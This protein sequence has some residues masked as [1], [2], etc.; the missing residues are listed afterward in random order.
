M[1]SQLTLNQFDALTLA[2]KLA[3]FGN[4][5]FT[6]K[7]CMILKSM[8]AFNESSLDSEDIANDLDLSKRSV[9]STI[10]SLNRKIQGLIDVD[11]G[12]SNEAY[13][14][15]DN[16]ALS[17]VIC[18][19]ELIEMGAIDFIEEAPAQEI[20]ETPAQEIEET[21]AQETPFNLS[22]TEKCYLKVGKVF[23]QQV[24][25]LSLDYEEKKRQ[26][27]F[28]RNLADS[29]CS[30]NYEKADEILSEFY[31]WTQET[32]QKR[33]FL[34]D[35]ESTQ[36][37]EETPAQK[38]TPKRLKPNTLKNYSAKQLAK[39]LD[40]LQDAFIDSEKDALYRVEHGAVYVYEADDNAYYFYGK[41]RESSL[42]AISHTYRALGI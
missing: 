28:I 11:H 33:N 38:N 27:E 20:E 41:T 9:S 5:F 21:P 24:K 18:I 22:V 26:D 25:H 15:L 19:D 6:A 8:V 14:T 16:D 36:E 29:I 13:Y 1:S 7:Q 12:W 30:N 39:H 10:S 23:N 35:Q 32:I 37:A 2:E 17:S 31:Q 3:Q 34:K 4:K 42:S 40:R